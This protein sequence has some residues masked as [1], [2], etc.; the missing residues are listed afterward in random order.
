MISPGMINKLLPD[1]HEHLHLYPSE[2]QTDSDQ[3]FLLA[4]FQGMLSGGEEDQNPN[5]ARWLEKYWINLDADNLPASDTGKSSALAWH[6][7]WWDLM[8]VASYN[9]EV[10]EMVLSEHRNPDETEEVTT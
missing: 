8:L 9:V 2:N 10:S 6:Y 7:K 5:A 3:F 4:W 1:W